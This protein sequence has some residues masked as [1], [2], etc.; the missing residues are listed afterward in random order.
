M[1]NSEQ[2]I[3]KETSINWRCRYT[4]VNLNCLKKL[5]NEQSSDCV[6]FTPDIIKIDTDSLFDFSKP[7]WI[8]F[9]QKDETNTI[10]IAKHDDGIFV[11]FMVSFNSE[12]INEIINEINL[13]STFEDFWGKHI[14]ANKRVSYSSSWYAFWT[15]CLDTNSR[16]LLKIT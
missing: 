3:P 9:F 6:I 15:F 10:L 13:N 16:T 8:Y 4:F 7:V 2:N 1:I 12:I 14:L 11:H 5:F